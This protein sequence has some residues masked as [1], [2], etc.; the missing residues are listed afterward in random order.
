MSCTIQKL[1]MDLSQYCVF[2]LSHIHECEFESVRIM[3]IID[4]DDDSYQ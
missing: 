3:Y 1:Y 4:E 2:I